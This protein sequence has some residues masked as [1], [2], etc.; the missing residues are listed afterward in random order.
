[1]NTEQDV[2][3]VAVDFVELAGL[4]NLRA[5]WP[6]VK[7]VVNTSVGPGGGNPELLLTGTAQALKAFLV[8]EDYGADAE[9]ADYIIAESVAGWGCQS[10]AEFAEWEKPW[11][12]IVNDPGFTPIAADVAAFF[13]EYGFA[14]YRKEMSHADFV[15]LFKNSI[16]DF[17]V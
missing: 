15:E 5:K 2:R 1:M 3:T 4:T 12:A 13:L 11:L 6:A 8:S 10:T 14:V 7:F 17:T 9:D 16:K